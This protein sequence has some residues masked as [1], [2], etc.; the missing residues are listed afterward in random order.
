M[1]RK[2]LNV[3]VESKSNGKYIT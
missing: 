2:A 3:K 1:L